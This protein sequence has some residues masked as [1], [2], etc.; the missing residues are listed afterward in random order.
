M[1][2]WS[3]TKKQIRR[4]PYQ[5]FVAIILMFLTLLLVGMVGIFGF[6]SSIILQH[7]ESKPQLTVFFSDTATV[8]SIQTLKNAMETTGKTRSIKFISKEDALKI[9]Q[10]QNK[11]DPLLLEMVTA[12]IL[13]ASLE[14]YATTPEYLSDLE[15]V[16]HTG[17]DVE[18][19]VYQKDVVD[20]LILWTTT[21]RYVGMVGVILLTFVSVFTVMT[22]ISL[23]IALK[24]DEIEILHLVGASPSYIR[25]PFIL[26]GIIYGLSGGVIS[27]IVFVAVFLWVRPFAAS[28]LGT[29]PELALILTGPIGASVFLAISILFGLLIFVGTFLGSIGSIIALRRFLAEVPNE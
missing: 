5:A 3:N 6:A 15:T 9:Y 29:I 14:I 21:I 7:F 26:E 25:G 18:E 16:A 4:S 11:N 28:F 13:P 12:D 20:T 27:F 8:D 10:E 24:R 17:K 22:V 1:G 19:V 2:I 23:K